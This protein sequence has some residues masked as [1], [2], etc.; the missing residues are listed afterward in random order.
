M[1]PSSNQIQNKSSVSGTTLTEA[2]NN[3]Q[4]TITGTPIEGLMLK[5]IYDTDDDGVVDYAGSAG[6]VE[7]INVNSKP[8]TF[9]PSTHSHS[10]AEVTSLQ[11]SLDSKQA[12]LVSG[13]NIKTINGT[14][15]LGSGDIT[16]SGGG[17]AVVEDVIVDGVTDK[18]PSQNAVFDGLATKA[19]TSH[20]HAI[21]DV[22]NLQTTLDGKAASSHTHAISDVTGLQTTLD[23]KVVGPVSSTNNAVA[24]FDGTTGKLVKDSAKT[25]PTGSLVGTTDT[26]TLSSKTITGL[27]ETKVAM[28]ASDIDLSSGNVF[29]KTISGTTTLTVSNVPTTGTV[30]SFILKL[31]NGGS[32]TVNWFSGVKWPGGTAPTLTAAGRDNI[33]FETDDGGTTW[34]GSFLKDVK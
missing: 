10:I 34:D 25:L 11:S 15:V 20:T 30:A 5:S 4:S 17:G 26:Q 22:T 13:T 21:S 12:T 14:S 3:L 2:L 1:K 29:T 23:G 28:G 19:N 6:S 24:L 33:Y 31:T 8:A 32:A 16:I 27:K 18:A 7:W 9:T